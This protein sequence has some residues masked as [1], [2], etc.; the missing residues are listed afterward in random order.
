ML[1]RARPCSRRNGARRPVS[2][3]GGIL[4]VLALVATALVGVSAFGDVAD[5]GTVPFKSAGLLAYGDAALF[6]SPTNTT[7]NAPVVGMAATHTG[8]GYWITAADGG[9]ARLRRR[10]LPRIGRWYRP[11]RTGHRDHRD[12]VGRRVL[13]ARARRGRVL[14]RRRHLPRLDGRHAVEPTGCRDGGDTVG[15]GLLAG[16]ER[17]WGVLVRRRRLPRLDRWDPPQPVDRRHGGHAVGPGLLVGGERW[18][19]LRL[20]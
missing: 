8:S 11:V 17:R 7:V 9:V 5:A 20:R 16:G 4:A 14:L 13:A 18:R 10:P 19:H 12:P 15:P 1:R 3:F 6:G 2:I